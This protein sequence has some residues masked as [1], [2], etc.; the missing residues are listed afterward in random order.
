MLVI[1]PILAVQGGGYISPW[2]VIPVLVVLWL[3]A[4]LLSWADKD[5]EAAHL[6]RV[7]L[8]LA[9]MSGLVLAFGLFF[10]LPTFVIS[11]VAV[12]LLFCVE[13][14][15]YLALRNKQVGLRDLQK[16]FLE[17]LKNINKAKDKDNLKQQAGQVIIMGKDGKALPVPEADSPDRPA[18]DTLQKALYESMIR[19]AQQIELAPEPGSDEMAVKY[20]VDNFPHR[21]ATVDRINGSAAISYVKWAA[22]LNIEDRRKPQTGMLKTII[23]KQKHELR[24]QTAG[25]TAGE[26][27]RVTV[28]PKT[29]H[30]Y[31]LSDLG[32][33]ETQKKLVDDLIKVNKGGLVLLSAPKG[34]G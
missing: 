10:L 24:V 23:E 28:D 6:P 20:V 14:G 5:A 33:S 30:T 26:S 7:P 21:G 29:R 17:Y 34:M 25:T 32:F 19:G 2:K 27:L 1:D 12:L 31:K 15:V 3:W 9:N 8:N 13:A 16:Q 11:F 4:R 22:G 18:Y